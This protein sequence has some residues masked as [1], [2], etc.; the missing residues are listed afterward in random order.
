M[1]FAGRREQLSQPRALINWPSCREQA[2]CKWSAKPNSTRRPAGLSRLQR[3]SVTG[4]GED[5]SDGEDVVATF[6]LIRY[7]SI[8]AS[9][10][11]I[12]FARQ[13][14]RVSLAR[15]T[16]SNFARQFFEV[17]L[18]N[19]CCAAR[20]SLRL[21]KRCFCSCRRLVSDR[22]CDGQHLLEFSSHHAAGAFVDI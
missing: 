17:G 18:F 14:S 15:R 6:F 21:C 9:R 22:V 3:V 11:D 20:Q 13:F 16:E 5:L 10:T 7:Q 12:N 19:N 2:R 8:V 4:V 1:V